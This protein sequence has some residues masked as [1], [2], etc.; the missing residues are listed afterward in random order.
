MAVEK[1][2]WN[3]V[4][5]GVGLAAEPADEG[6]RT[7]IAPRLAG[8]EGP[9]PTLRAKASAVA[10]HSLGGAQSGLDVLEAYLPVEL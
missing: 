2:P 9:L 4:Q 6:F 5:V 10:E 3:A 8:Y 1:L 7:M